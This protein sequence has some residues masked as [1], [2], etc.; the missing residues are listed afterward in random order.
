[1][2]LG[3]CCALSSELKT[4]TNRKIQLGE[5][6]S[7]DGDT[8]IALSGM[9]SEPARVTAMRLIEQGAS[10]LLCWGS[11]AALDEHLSPGTLIVPNKVVTRDG[12]LISACQDW[13]RRLSNRLN[14]RFEIQT[15]HLV[16]TSVVL[17]SIHQKRS[18]AT[19]RKAI[20]AD[21]ETAAVAETCSSHNIPWL[22]IRAISDSVK[23]RIPEGLEHAV[24]LAGRLPLNYLLTGI[25]LHPKDWAAIIRLALG[26]HSALASLKAIFAVT[27]CKDLR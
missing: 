23:T 2:K 14:K 9:G 21:M 20:A 22:A 5:I 10:S 7:M 15:G 8:L 13:H 17:T 1:M 18:L 12:K 25:I 4:L 19:K 27:G 11:A 26:M 16:E 3:I 24:D 6:I